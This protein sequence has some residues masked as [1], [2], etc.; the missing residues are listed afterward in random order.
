MRTLV[1]VEYCIDY[2]N[3]LRLQGDAPVAP[4]RPA[5]VP[6]A[7]PAPVPARVPAAVPAVA[8]VSMLRLF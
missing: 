4:A 1:G 3:T 8:G 6:A 2:L 5:P 7:V